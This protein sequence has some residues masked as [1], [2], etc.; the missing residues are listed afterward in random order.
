M[1]DW[2]SVGAMVAVSAFMFVMGVLFGISFRKGAG[3]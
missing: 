3:R 2:V 1:I